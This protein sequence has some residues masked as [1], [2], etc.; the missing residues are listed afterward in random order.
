MEVDGDRGHLAKKLRS[1]E[2]KHAEME[3]RHTEEMAAMRAMLEKVN[4]AKVTTV[5]AEDESNGNK[6]KLPEKMKLS[7][8]NVLNCSQLK[9]VWPKSF[10]MKSNKRNIQRKGD[11]L[12]ADGTQVPGVDRYDP[13]HVNESGHDGSPSH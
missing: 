10:Q 2:R 11:Y 1:A 4:L 9:R 8:P 12:E 5:E 13:S 7:H 3:K 6:L